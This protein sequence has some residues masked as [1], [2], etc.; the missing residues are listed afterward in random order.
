MTFQILSKSSG[1][2]RLAKWT[3]AT[4]NATTTTKWM[5]T[6]NFLAYTR[7]ACIPP[8]TPDLVFSDQDH[9]NERSWLSNVQAVQI[10]LD[11]M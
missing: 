4:T 5:E 10:C 6:P 9:Q 2:A 7:K 8:L 1:K 3:V 11:Q